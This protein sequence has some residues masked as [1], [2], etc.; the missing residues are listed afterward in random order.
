M[1]ILPLVLASLG[2]KGEGGGKVREVGELVGPLALN[3]L[4]IME[5]GGREGGRGRNDSAPNI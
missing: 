5:V 2:R 1:S 4:E 3:Y